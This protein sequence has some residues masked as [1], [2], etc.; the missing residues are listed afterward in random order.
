[1]ISFHT[2]TIIANCAP[3]LPTQGV[4]SFAA[5]H[6]SILSQEERKDGHPE[7][8]AKAGGEDLHGA[9]VQREEE[10]TARHKIRDTLSNGTCLTTTTTC[11]PLH[12]TTRC[13]T[14]SLVAIPH[15]TLSLIASLAHVL[16][17][18]LR[19]KSD[20]AGSGPPLRPLTLCSTSLLTQLPCIWPLNTTGSKPPLLPLPICYPPQRPP[21]GAAPG[22]WTPQAA[23]PRVQQHWASKTTPAPPVHPLYS[24]PCPHHHLRF[25]CCRCCWPP[26]DLWAY[27]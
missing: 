20:T 18:P 24:P 19:T 5:T 16:N 6:E 7:A 27:P 13:H 1:M 12:P 14:P 3:R 26:L 9:M 17:A 21:V 22:P 4:S 11:S 25:R 23:H 15:H 8:C 2:N 10:G